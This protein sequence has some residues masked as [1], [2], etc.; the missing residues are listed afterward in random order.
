MSG[1]QGENR[2][3]KVARG[4]RKRR[5]QEG[6]MRERE[7]QGAQS[8]EEQRVRRSGEGRGGRRGGRWGPAGSAAWPQA[9]LLFLGRFVCSQSYC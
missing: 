9:D 4:T 2:G 6:G 5:G 1:G 3:E 7:P 8:E